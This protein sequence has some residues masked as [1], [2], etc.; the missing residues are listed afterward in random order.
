MYFLSEEE[1]KLL[2]RGLI[3]KSRENE[4]KEDLRGWNWHRPPLEPLYGIKMALY[5]IAS[6]YCPPGRDVYLRRVQGVK[7][8]PTRAMILGSMFHETLV[9]VI[10]KAKSLIYA[11]GVD[12][13]Q[14]VMRLLR[15][16]DLTRHEKH[17]SELGEEFQGALERCRI[18]WEFETDR[19]CA[20]LQE[21][22]SKQPHI[23]PDSLVSL[24][25]P[26]VVEQKLDGSFLGLSTNLS[27]DA[28]AFSEPMVVDLKFGQRKE[29]HRLSTTGYALVMEALHEY[30]INIG[31]IVYAEFR[32]D[33]VVISRDFHLID[34]EL[35]QWLIEERDE[36]MRMVI[37][38]IDP[39]LPSVCNSCCPYRPLCL[40]DET[41]E[42]VD[43]EACSSGIPTR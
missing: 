34:D 9:Q 3:P 33:R 7:A 10:V 41:K 40:P 38:E 16:P 18:I 35:R 28:F 14:E 12:S 36:K 25:I 31:C 21:Y 43:E 23:G 26:V 8:P 5:E 24:A 30:P 27:A 2:L 11:K 22:L 29:F 32:N 15:H 17:R 19:I 37:E 1:R 6:K 13:H 4:V 39:G 20:R 42:V